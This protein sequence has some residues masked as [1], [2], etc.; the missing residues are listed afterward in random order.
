MLEA[1]PERTRRHRH[2]VA[3]GLRGYHRGPRRRIA[4]DS[5]TP[6]RS[7]RK[8]S[9]PLSATGAQWLAAA[10]G[11]RGR[12]S[13]LQLPVARRKWGAAPVRVGLTF[14]LPRHAPRG[15]QDP[16]RFRPGRGASP[17]G[18]TVACGLHFPG[19]RQGGK[20]E[21][22][23]GRVRAAELRA[24]SDGLPLN[25]LPPVAASRPSVAPASLA[26]AFLLGQISR[27]RS[28]AP[29]RPQRGEPGGL[30]VPAGPAP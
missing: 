28:R 14:L 23:S 19:S 30:Q 22:A 2:R 4:A 5:Q 11:D 24:R 21:S 6:S 9:T 12:V 10:S 13:G 27:S 8:Q 15:S 3:L 29:A 17:I 26:P 20:R 18:A 1:R 25:L 7:R 16:R